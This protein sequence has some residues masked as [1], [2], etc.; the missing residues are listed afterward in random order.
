MDNYRFFKLTEFS[1][2][3]AVIPFATAQI[4]VEKDAC[5]YVVS[6]D[7]IFIRLDMDKGVTLDVDIVLTD[8]IKECLSNDEEDN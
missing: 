8:I 4:E 1:S 3:I 7:D 5:A 6:G 2:Q